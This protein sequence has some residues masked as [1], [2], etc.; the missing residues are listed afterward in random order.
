LALTC[1][2]AKAGL[3]VLHYWIASSRCSL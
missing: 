2:P 1:G 3:L